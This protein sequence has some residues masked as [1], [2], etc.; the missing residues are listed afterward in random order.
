[1][2]SAD[3]GCSPSLGGGDAHTER[4]KL[5]ATQKRGNKAHSAAAS[6]LSAGQGERRA[7]RTAKHYAVGSP[8]PPRK[9]G[10]NNNGQGAYLAYQVPGS[11]DVRGRLSISNRSEGGGVGELYRGCQRLPVFDPTEPNRESG[12]AFRRRRGVV[13]NKLR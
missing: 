8:G 4:G 6:L 13:Y 3:P 2:D 10:G 7:P 1:M 9:R 5:V 11:P 12:T